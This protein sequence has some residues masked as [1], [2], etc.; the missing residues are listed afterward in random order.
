M[1]RL[2]G[3]SPS[4]SEYGRLLEVCLRDCRILPPILETQSEPHGVIHLENNENN[5]PRLIDD[6]NGFGRC[7][8]LR[9]QW[10][11]EA[12]SIILQND[13]SSL[14][15]S[16]GAGWSDQS[17]EF[18]ERI[19]SDALTSLE[20][21]SQKITDVSHMLRFTS[22]RKIGLQTRNAANFVS[23]A[24]PE[25]EYLAYSWT[26]GGILDTLSGSLTVLK[27]D[28]YPYL[29]FLK[30]PKAQNL[31]ALLIGAR[32]L[33]TLNGLE[34]FPLVQ[35]ITILDAGKLID[36]SELGNIPD[37]QRLFLSGAISIFDL[38]PVSAILDLR[39]LG[40]NSCSDIK[41]LAP[42]AHMIEM[43]TLEISG[44]TRIVDG[45]LS[46]VESMKNLRWLEIVPRKHYHPR[47][48]SLLSKIN[49]NS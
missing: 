36:I 29:D 12:E 14:R 43:E 26:K 13:V 18:L 8:I 32:K 48:S 42:I 49:G 35:D 39:H 37:L 38:H 11:N 10:N 1:E 47:V 28:K 46:V 16:E 3:K 6:E 23:S 9:G 45:D 30:I 20:I 15:L 33:S 34:K 31:R 25:L 24:F 19:P 4:T 2:H 44:N 21:Y 40:L 17:L 5:S 22:L 7:L 27:I 41:S